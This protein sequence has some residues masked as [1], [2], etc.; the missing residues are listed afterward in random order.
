[1]EKSLLEQLRTLPAD[2]ATATVQGVAM[3][4]IDDATRQSLLQSD[5]EDTH[6]HECTLSNGT[7]IADMQNGR[8]VAL[9]KVR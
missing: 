6:I 1:M 3:Q 2:A 7:F 5:P 9:Y 4:V 8:L